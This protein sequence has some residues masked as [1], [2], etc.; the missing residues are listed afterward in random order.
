ME[1]LARR[2]VRTTVA[3]AGLAALGVGLATPAFAAPNVPDVS[4][5]GSIPTNTATDQLAGSSSEFTKASDALAKLPGKFNFA[6]PTVDSTTMPSDQ[7]PSDATQA[8][9]TTTPEA[10]AATPSTDPASAL[11]TALPSLPASPV[12]TPNV[13]ATPVS[14]VDPGSALQA[15]D[16]AG[17]FG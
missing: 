12:G 1:S 9:D 16:S 4:G 5:V 11:P 17:L 14:N 8:P 7:T 10:T 15:L 13:Q 3:V 6:M 2:G